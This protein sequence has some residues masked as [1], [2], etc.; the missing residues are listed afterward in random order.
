MSLFPLAKQ[1]NTLKNSQ[2]PMKMDDSDADAQHRF[3]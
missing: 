2:E 3:V 1:E